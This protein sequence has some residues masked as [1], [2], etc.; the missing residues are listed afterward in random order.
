MS[1]P[2]EFGSA[3][4]ALLFAV[5]CSASPPPPSAPSPPPRLPPAACIDYPSE[6]QDVVSCRY[7][8]PAQANEVWA[9]STQLAATSAIALGATHIQWLS[10]QTSVESVQGRAPV[11]C[12]PTWGAWT[13]DGGAYEM[14]VGY[15]AV[16]RFGFLS[17]AEA[18]ARASDPLVPTERQP[19][20]A[21]RIVAATPR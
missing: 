12:K 5:G 8:S 1:Q 18:A 7:A 17:A 16:T 20:D 6:R 9:R 13:C 15:I 19:I 21:H 3:L 10:A 14:P 4:N 2:R 11:E